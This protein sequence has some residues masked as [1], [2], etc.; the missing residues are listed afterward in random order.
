LPRPGAWLAAVSA[1]AG[2]GFTE[3]VLGADD[4]HHRLR[5]RIAVGIQPIDWLAFSLRVDGRYDTHTVGTLSDDGLVGDPRFTIRAGGDLGGF[6]LGG[7]ATLWVPGVDAP[8][9]E[10]GATSIDLQLLAGLAA[11][12]DLTF[13]VNLGARID[14]SAST[15][16][17]P[18][19]VAPG[20]DL[21]PA[22]HMSLGVSPNGAFLLGIGGAY[23][24]EPAEIFV[25][26]TWDMIL[27]ENAPDVTQ[28]PMRVGL[29]GRLWLGD[30]RDPARAR[31]GHRDERAARCRGRLSAAHADRAAFRGVPRCDVPVPAAGLPDGD[32]RRRR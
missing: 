22:D 23:R 25:E 21:S 2:Y 30:T 28:S 26:F 14:N 6:F 16:N 24:L 15:L 5:G 18:A 11:T 3:S 10:F 17:P 29:G 13:A 27:G 8:S 1:S 32:R 12:D 31:R 9:L 4:S 19:G 20:Q 7:Q